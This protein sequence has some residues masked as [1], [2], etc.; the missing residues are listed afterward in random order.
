MRFVSGAVGLVLVA[1]SAMSQLPQT[2]DGFT[3]SAGLGAGS[4]GLSCTT[5]QT[6]RTNGLSG[7]LRLG[8]AL[9]QSITLAV[10]T[11]GW[12]HSETNETDTFSYLNGVILWYPNA[13]GGFYLK[14]GAGFSNIKFQGQGQ[15]AGD[16]FESTD[17]GLIGGVGYDIRVAPSFSLTPF[18]NMLTGFKSAAQTS[19]TGNLVQIGIGATWP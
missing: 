10:E 4:A 7:Y 18:L 9:S 2:R 19:I 15:L 11:S 14:G 16:A 6:T 8:G 13:M 3:F 1:S 17:L 5:C 12:Q